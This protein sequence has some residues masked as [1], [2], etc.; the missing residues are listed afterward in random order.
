M[1]STN[2]CSPIS[3]TGWTMKL[4]SL[5]TVMSPT[6]SSSCPAPTTGKIDRPR[7]LEVRHQLPVRLVVEFPPGRLRVGLSVGVE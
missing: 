4:F 7:R 2:S 5:L 3:P 6:L 1:W